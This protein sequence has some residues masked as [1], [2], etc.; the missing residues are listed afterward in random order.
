[1]VAILKWLIIFLVIARVYGGC[2]LRNLEVRQYDTGKLVKGYHEY[3]VSIS[4][5]C[6]ELCVQR[7]VKLNCTGFQTVEKVQPSIFRV[8]G[9]V[10]VV[11]NG[12][13]IT[14]DATT[15]FRYAWSNSFHFNPISS[16][17]HCYKS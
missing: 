9:D 16:D 17:I 15:N 8:S 12:L 14:S 10:C 5:K 4:N 11:N 1:M 6:S 13:P 7:H 2:S 3:A